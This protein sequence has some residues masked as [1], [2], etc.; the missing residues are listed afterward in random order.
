MKIKKS[1]VL[2]DNTLGQGLCPL[3]NDYHSVGHL[4]KMLWIPVNFILRQDQVSQSHTHTLTFTHTHNVTIGKNSPP[5]LL[6]RKEI[7]QVKM[8]HFRCLLPEKKNK[9]KS[10]FPS[11]EYLQN[12]GREVKS[13]MLQFFLLSFILSIHSFIQ[14]MCANHPVCAGRRQVLWKTSMLNGEIRLVLIHPFGKAGTT[15]KRGVI[16][17]WAQLGWATAAPLTFHFNRH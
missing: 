2:S 13:H 14:C 12:S 6:C 15:P 4:V 1:V 16:R 11:P 7:F 10:G 5:M 8:H 17:E 9:T 3:H